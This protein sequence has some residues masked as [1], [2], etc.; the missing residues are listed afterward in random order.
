MNA[1][2]ITGSGNSA[3]P[4]TSNQVDVLKK[5]KK[6]QTDTVCVNPLFEGI[7]REA[8]PPPTRCYNIIETFV[9][10]LLISTAKKNPDLLK[11]QVSESARPGD[12]GWSLH[13]LS[14][15]RDLW[16]EEEEE[17]EASCD[18]LV[19]RAELIPAG[20]AAGI[21][22]SSARSALQGFL[23]FCFLNTTAA[24]REPHV[25][26]GA[27]GRKDPPPLLSVQLKRSQIDTVS[28]CVCE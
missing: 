1:S 5:K 3:H 19:V 15:D 25:S 13:M 17:V 18:R 22:R 20:T 14:L 10:F 6:S 2:V 16:V 8:P 21:T 27:S 7:L 26:H 12:L 28:S 11:G 23:S 9:L 4:D 24:I